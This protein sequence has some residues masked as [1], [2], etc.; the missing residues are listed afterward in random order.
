MAQPREEIADRSQQVGRAV[1]ILDV[2]GVQ[3]GANQMTAGIGNDVTLAPIDLL[4]RIISP[5]TS[6]FRGLD[7]LTVDHPCRRAGFAALPL[8]SMLDQ[9]EVDLFPQPFRLPRIKVTLHCRPLRKIARQQTPR[10]RRPQN[11]EQGVDNTPKPN[12]SRPS[13]G[14]LPRQ[15]RR[16][17]RPFCI[18]H[19]TC[20][21]QIFPPILLPS[22][23]SPHLV[24]PLPSDTAWVSQRSEIAQFIS[25]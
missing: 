1:A 7:R 14:L 9:Q 16:N 3:L 17:Q 21:A 18:R 8:P 2:G 15:V 23:F 11:I 22:G 19:V 24:S 10:T 20:I 25:S 12:Y 5:R 6:A 13:H 4:A